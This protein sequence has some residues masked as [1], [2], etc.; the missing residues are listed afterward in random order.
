MS[1]QRNP[2]KGRRAALYLLAV[3]GLAGYS[4]SRAEEALGPSPAP[5]SSAPWTAP[6]GR[7]WNLRATPV[8]DVVRRVKEAVVNIHSERTAQAHHTDDFFQVAPSQG[9]VNGMGTG[10]II[11]PRGFLLTNQH[12]VDEVHS[13]RV[14]LADGTSTPARV[15]ARD[16]DADLALLKIDVHK[17]LPTMPL[18]TSSDLLVG[19]TVIAI[20]NAFGY[21]HTVT[22]G[23]VSAVARDVAL[24]KEVSYKALIQTDASINPGNSGGPLLNVK[25][26]LVGLNVAIRAGAQ[27]IGFAIPVDSVVKVGA[28]LLAQASGGSRERRASSGRSS[29]AH[30][31]TGLVVRDQ[32]HPETSNRDET[33]RSLVVEAVEPD[34]PAQKAGVRPGDIL[35]QVGDVPCVCGIDLERAVI[36]EQGALLGSVRLSIRVKREGHEQR[37]ELALEARAEPAVAETT[38][39]DRPP[40]RPAGRPS[41][42]AEGATE[43][44]WRRLGLRLQSV[45]AE[46]V[47]RSHPQLRGGLTVIDV[48]PD[49]PAERSGIQR[50]DV[51]VGLHQWE[52]L[53]LDNV[54][55][56]LNH[57]DLATFQPMRFYILRAGQVHRGWLQGD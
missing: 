56:V 17:L 43:V 8:V 33:R 16:P 9:R 57:P 55:F 49:S 23:V 39:N 45:G 19:E 42:D 20:G 37:V 4:A 21:E 44:V 34:S 10:V 31:A 12:V 52:M 2:R 54:L 18:G 26:E 38:T 51:L 24:N 32:V 27:G 53:N 11:D 47:S 46:G 48:R 25:G 13:L 14:R 36:D 28:R 35:L 3:A 50:L 41:G 22:V 1:T 40:T 7:D 29:G 30:A 5:R 15:L 6:A